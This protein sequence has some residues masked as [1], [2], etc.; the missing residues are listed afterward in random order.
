MNFYRVKRVEGVAIMSWFKNSPAHSLITISSMLLKGLLSTTKSRK[1]CNAGVCGGCCWKRQKALKRNLKTA[2]GVWV[3]KGLQITQALKMDY[4][5]T[6]KGSL[7]VN[8][9]QA[10]AVQLFAHQHLLKP[11]LV[12]LILENRF[13]WTLIKLTKEYNFCLLWGVCCA[14]TGRIALNQLCGKL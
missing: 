13:D 8:R 14:L 1:V 7:N 10:C 2:P 3:T 11:T 5:Y 9:N 6:Y 12:D 4:K